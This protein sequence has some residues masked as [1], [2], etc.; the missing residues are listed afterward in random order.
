[1]KANNFI[2]GLSLMF[3]LSA[4]VFGANLWEQ[5]CSDGTA[6]MQCSSTQPGQMCVPSGNMLVLQNVIGEKY[7]S[8]Y[9]KSS[10]AGKPTENAVKCACDNYAGYTE[11][12]GACVEIKTQQTTTTQPTVTQTNTTPT[13]TSATNTTTANTTKTDTKTNT[14]TTT[15]QNKADTVKTSTTK[16][17]TQST[18]TQ[19]TKFFGLGIWEIA[20][21]L[22]V[23]SIIGAV[24][25]V[26]IIIVVALAVYFMRKKR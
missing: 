22:I 24:V 1:M 2:F 7:P 20:G 17:N 16:T 15:T 6:Y 10:L 14:A 23:L 19:E 21:I 8:D 12:D 4:A 26:G 13:T 3:L 9:P 5:K 25:V 11:K 18:T